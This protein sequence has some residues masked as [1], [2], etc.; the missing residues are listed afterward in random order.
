MRGSGSVSGGRRMIDGGSATRDE[1]QNSGL[2]A[3]QGGMYD[4]LR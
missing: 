1:G 2:E 3:D 4:G